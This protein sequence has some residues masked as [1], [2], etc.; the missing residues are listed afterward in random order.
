MPVVVVA[1]LRMTVKTQAY[2][3]V[4]LAA[5]AI[6]FRN[7]VMNFHLCSLILATNTAVTRGLDKDI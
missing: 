5:P 6:R 4:F 2:S 3:I 7:D 1:S